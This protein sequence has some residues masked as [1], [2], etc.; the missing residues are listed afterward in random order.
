MSPVNL[1]L[2]YTSFPR[3]ISNVTANTSIGKV[4]ATQASPSRAF[5]W[6]I[7]QL[8]SCCIRGHIFAT[9][10]A[11]SHPFPATFSSLASHLVLVPVIPILARYQIP[12]HLR[13][14]PSDRPQPHLKPPSVPP[15]EA[16]DAGGRHLAARSAVSPLAPAPL[17]GLRHRRRT[18][19]SLN[20]PLLPRIPHWPLTCHFQGSLHLGV[21][22][23]ESPC[24]PVR[25]APPATLEV[26]RRTP[27]PLRRSAPR[28]A[29][30]GLAAGERSPPRSSCQRGAGAGSRPSA[31]QRQRRRRR[32]PCSASRAAQPGGEREGDGNGGRGR[33][34]EAR[35]AAAAA[36]AGGQRRPP[37]ARCS[38]RS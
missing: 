31:R 38:E 15:S 10:S 5:T 6:H 20:P 19:L 9:R 21:N 32:A 37:R 23:P 29:R 2:G 14:Q 3:G 17:P 25:T 13:W 30:R 1:L 27:T 33:P 34:E 35:R 22:K 8:L 24:S 11:P 18:P 4:Y 7:S 28:Y 16:S 36:A 26:P 12:W